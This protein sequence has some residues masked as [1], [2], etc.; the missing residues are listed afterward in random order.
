M[1]F[2]E[3]LAKKEYYK[4]LT[5]N[6][7]NPIAFLGQRYDEEQQRKNHDLSSIRFGQGE[8]Y[9]HIKDYE[10]AIFKWG[11]I[12][13]EYQS[14]AKK[15]TADAYVKIGQLAQAEELYKGIVTD[16]LILN[17][18]IGLQLF[19]LYEQSGNREK[20]TSTI[21]WVISLNPDY[22]TVTEIARRYYEEQE[23][24]RNAVELAVNEG[25]RTESLLW[26]S[27]LRNYV[28]EGVTKEVVPEYFEES[29]LL[30]KNLNQPHFEQLLSSLWKSYEG[31]DNY[32][33]WVKS[34]IR[35]FGEM[36]TEEIQWHETQGIYNEVFFTLIS[37][38]YLLKD[39]ENIIPNFLKNWVKIVD[40]SNL[41]FVYAAV[42]SWNDFFPMT[43]DGAIVEKAEGFFMRETIQLN[44]IDRATDVLTDILTWGKD[45]LMD[46]ED[47]LQFKG[48]PLLREGQPDI[49]SVHEFLE[50]ETEA[51]RNESMLLLIR[52]MLNS[53]LDQKEE[54]KN[55]LQKSIK[56][57]E[58]VLIKLNGA[59]H[60]LDD[61]KYGKNK[62]IKNAF[63]R[64]KE[65]MEAKIQK[66]IPEILRGCSE[67]LNEEYDINKIQIGINEEMNRRIQTYFNETVLPQFQVK[68]QEWCKKA[69]IE[70]MESKLFM[71]ELTEGLNP[72]FA[73][74][75]LQLLG[76][77][78][79]LNDWK[80]DMER[81]TSFFA[82]EEETIFLRSSP[83]QLLL[84]GAGKLLS[85]IPQNSGFL[86]N[87]YK[88]Q[89]ET[90]DYSEIAASI[91]NKFL[92]PFVLFERTLERDIGMFFRDSVQTLK[93]IID[94]LE[95]QKE[96]DEKE[97]QE[98]KV[99]PER[100]YD[101]I[102]LFQ[103]RHR[104]LEW[105]NIAIVNT[106]NL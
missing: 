9:F 28:D 48:K 69:D 15:N 105:L 84:K 79:V 4:R 82:Y 3:Q 24:W 80:R 100:F 89:I 44:T 46:A 40:E 85:A 34:L 78:Q 98:L 99:N 18:E 64:K 72:L 66:E 93:E 57:N 74:E 54:Q 5:E 55:T 58:E 106:P 27:I 75:Q 77:F 101:P 6:A 37:G 13:N 67:L 103:I 76:D 12:Q 61:L 45:A 19:T 31:E 90:E 97:L 65:E 33:S 95:S 42:L 32:L 51:T 68:F 91:A 25:I 20:A 43:L 17:T 73:E 92:Q 11:K 50:T 29:L 81:M 102:I 16:S 22:P 49:T 86:L 23:D 63:Q 38:K 52:N 87:H 26:F 71:D 56:W 104:Q 14:W 35:L 10:T 62:V 1:S 94:S 70:F 88:K 8:L 2:E 36:E 59:L 41:P 30:L 53:L 47:A 39:I 96:L 21:K 60:Q 83:S 7:P